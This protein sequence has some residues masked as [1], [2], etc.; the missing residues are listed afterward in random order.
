M[1]SALAYRMARVLA[2]LRR[3][4]RDTDGNAGVEFAL[5]APVM[6]M[7]T[8]ATFDLG[9]AISD[10]MAMDAAVRNGLQ[11]A[12]ITGSVDETL[13]IMQTTANSELGADQASFQVSQICTC[14]T[15]SDTRVACTTVCTGPEP[16][17][18]FIQLQGQYSHSSW[19]LPDIN[20]SPMVY[21][22]KR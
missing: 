8:L 4:A 6:L 14:G 2:A 18:V 19:V 16:T 5:L 12:M 22:Q 13:T 10:R 7:I 9:K 15:V 11:V 17:S 20:L 21:L 1:G 3:F